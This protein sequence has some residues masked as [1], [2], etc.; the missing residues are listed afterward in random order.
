MLV[1]AGFR[2]REIRCYRHK[3]GLNTF[4]ACRVQ[5]RHHV[6]EQ[7]HRLFPG[8]LS[9]VLQLRQLQAQHGTPLLALAGEQPRFVVVEPHLDIVPLRSDSCLSAPNLFIAGV[10]HGDLELFHDE[11]Q[12]RLADPRTGRA[13]A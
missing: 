13:V 5:L 11:L 2:P 6:I 3:F 8:H 7:E 10:A 9:E 1:R 12:W 4:A